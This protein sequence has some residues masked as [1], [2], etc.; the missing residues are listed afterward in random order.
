MGERSF[1]KGSVQTLLPLS[2]NTAI[3]LTTARYYTPSGKSVQEGGI[4]PDITVP[5]LS[6]ADYKSRPRLRE[7]DL[8]RHL[9]NELKVEDDVVQDDGKPDPRFAATPDQL[10]KQGITDFQLH[11][12][13]QTI[14]RL[15]KTQQAAAPAAGAKKGTR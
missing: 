2:Q 8:R 12:A 9:I 13:L 14:S 1:G 5:Q 7:A 10:K 4:T 15:G 11:Y 3:R 6:D